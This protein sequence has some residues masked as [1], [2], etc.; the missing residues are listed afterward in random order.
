M[1][2]ETWNEETDVV[3]IGFGGAGVATAVTAFDLGAEVT[4][5]EK[6]PEG[7]HGG[8]TRVAAQGYLNS[9]SEEEAATYLRA[10]CGRYPVPEEMVLVWAHEMCRNNEWLAGLG[11][12]PQEH[13]HPPAGIEFPELPGAFSSHKFHDGP[14]LGY[15]LTWQRFESFVH[16]RDIK[17][18]Y[19]A[20]ARELIQ[21][22]E[23]K[24]I[25]GVRAEKDGRPFTVK[26]RR[27][28]VLTCG[29]FENNQ[30]LIRTYLTG[31]PYC[32][33]S[34]TPYNEGD[35]IPMAQA[36]GADLWHMNNFAGPSMALKVP[37]FPATL[38]MQPLHFSKEF[39]GGMIVVGPDARRFGD[40]KFKT[41]HGK[42]PANGT[43]RALQVPCPMYM[44]FDRPLMEAG[45]LYNK[46]PNRGWTAMI[47]RY[48]WSDD[49]SAE[50]ER[51]WIKRADTLEALAETVGLD[52]AALRVTVERWNGQVSTGG[53]PDF[54]RKLMLAPLA[55]PPFHAVELSPSMINTQGGPRRNEQA[56]ILRPDGTPIPRL[57]SAGELGSIFSYLYQGT[58][59]IGE[60]L[61]FGRIAGR[62]AAAQS[63]WG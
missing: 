56:E 13:Q 44:I 2:P 45:P 29:G 46:E 22:P 11:G 43:W 19:E 16:E 17:V 34:G 35:G 18:H 28:V 25:L 15:G 5:L 52:P 30:E 31:V 9:S 58:G 10:L 48:D 7:L 8:N 40:E 1:I 23:S 36:V 38:S 57:Y 33:P 3:V 26:A 14:K 55:E 20:P 53:D 54:G 60:C 37:E 59:N 47:D 24:E 49:N 63:P 62:N 41:R 42:V 12:D 50:L 27:G 21:H 61:G 39:P 32:Y 51:G 4:I 6:A